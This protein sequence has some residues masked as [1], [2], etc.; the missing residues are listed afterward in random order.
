MM[1]LLGISKVL[2]RVIQQGFAQVLGPLFEVDFSEKSDGYRPGCS[3]LQA[4]A[5]MQRG[6]KKSVVARHST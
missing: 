5:V 3:A 6:W 1:C 4:V 2:D